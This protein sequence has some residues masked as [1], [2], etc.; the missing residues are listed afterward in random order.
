MLSSVLVRVGLCW[1]VLVCVAV[2]RFALVCVGLRWF[3]LV[4]VGL[5]GLWRLSSGPS[6][7]SA[8]A[9]R[10]EAPDC[11]HFENRI[12]IWKY[13]SILMKHKYE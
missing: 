11:S 6:H 12:K 5:L 8:A 4:C 3:A 7:S 9:A 1:F 13:G 10:D 2:C